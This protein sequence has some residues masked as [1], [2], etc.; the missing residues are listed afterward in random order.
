[1]D[2]LPAT[3][4]EMRVVPMA[5]AG[6]FLY[7]VLALLL[8]HAIRPDYTIVDHMIS[9]YAVGRSG[10]IMTTAFVSISLGCLALAIG[11]FRDGPNSLSGRVGAAL[12]VVAFAG[13]VVTA[14]FPTDLETA[15]TTHNGN[16]HTISF[17]VNV[18][19]IVLSA[20]CLAFSYGGS[21][22]WRHRRSPAFIFA[23]LLVVAFVA[24]F[25]T[26]HPAPLWDYQPAV[27]RG[28]DGVAPIEQFLVG[29]G[30]QIQSRVNERPLFGSPLR[31]T[32]P[33][34]DTTGQ[35]IWRH[36]I[37]ERMTRAFLWLAVLVGGPLFGAK[38]FDLL[39]LA[40]A[41]SAHPPASLAMMPYGK[42]WPV[43]TGVF[44][45]PFSAAMLLA[46]LG[47]L[48]AGGALRGIIAGCSACRR[49]VFC[50]CSFSPSS[51]SGR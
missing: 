29:V 20:L 7:F 15:P 50:S 22:T 14:L 24:Q 25:M 39:V 44:F 31:P 11:L 27:R 33:E 2:R 30:H 37:R 1:M 18:V 47:A 10:W 12:L 21:A 36:M 46:G 34:T 48:T 8:M 3:T 51:H 26:L 4:G 32:I 13:L 43:D 45:I 38:L 19:S 5:A 17:L 49:W 23:G 28:F 6:F 16:I 41:W 9:D 40:G 35:F 42:A